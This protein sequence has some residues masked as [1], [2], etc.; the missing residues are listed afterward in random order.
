GRT[1]RAGASGEAISFF[2][3]DE[4]RLLTDIEKLIRRKI[5]R[6]QLALPATQRRSRPA[7]SRSASGGYSR[8]QQPVDEFF[9]KPYVPSSPSARPGAAAAVAASDSRDTDRRR[10]V[11]VLLGGR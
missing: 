1:G 11:G 4:E 8:P 5:P 7:S 2:T 3:T 6:G 10:S 9:Y